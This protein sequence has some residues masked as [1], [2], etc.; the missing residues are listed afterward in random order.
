MYFRHLKK[1]FIGKCCCSNFRQIVVDL[2]VAECGKSF[3]DRVAYK[4]GFRD[5]S[6]KD[7]IIFP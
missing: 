3:K 6:I 5:L 7:E 4:Q 1:M 2:N